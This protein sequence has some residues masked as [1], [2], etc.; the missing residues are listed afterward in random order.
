MSASTRRFRRI[1][2][3]Q[4]FVAACVVLAAC[5]MTSVVAT[6]APPEGKGKGGG[7][8]QIGPSW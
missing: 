2:R 5:L 8:A 1:G 4:V 3:H 6:A 7:D